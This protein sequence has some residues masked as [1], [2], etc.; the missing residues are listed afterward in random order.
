MS[1]LIGMLSNDLGLPSRDLAYLVRSAPHRYKVYEIPKKTP[2]KKRTIAQPAKEVKPLQ[3]WVMN[4]VLS[5]FPVHQ[6]ATAYRRGRSI[7]DNAGPHA[8]HRYLCKLDF[9]NFFPSIKAKHF[10][11]FMKSNPLANIWTP[12]DV[13]LMSRI[14]F[15]CKKRGNA[16]QL[17]IGAPSSPLLSN[18]LMFEFDRRVYSMGAER[19]VAYTRYADDL[20]FSTNEPGVLRHI[21]SEIN[22]ICRAIRTP[23][24]VLNEE[25]TVHAS[26]RGLRLVTGLVLTNQGFVSI[27]REKKR[28]LRAAFHRYTQGLLSGEE[29]NELAGMLAFAKSVEP[30]FLQR[31]AARYGAEAVDHLMSTHRPLDLI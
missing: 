15:W 20:S 17:S 4:N 10:E 30:L 2:G 23:R 13:E 24:L 29:I 14:L 25:K 5:A 21:P 22:R 12:E 1:K 16:L 19:G 9:R 27:G 11:K 3:Y 18:V 7:L 28:N 8:P 6:A 31:L 26:K